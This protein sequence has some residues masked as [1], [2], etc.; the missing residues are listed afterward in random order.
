MCEKEEGGR[1]RTNQQHKSERAG[2]RQSKEHPACT[3]R[4]ILTATAGGGECLRITSRGSSCLHGF[5]QCSDI[6]VTQH[7]LD[8]AAIHAVGTLHT[9]TQV[10]SR[11]RKADPQRTTHRST[12]WISTFFADGDA[13]SIARISV[14]IASFNES[15]QDMSS[16]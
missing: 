15:S 1:G 9:H 16:L 4:A 8:H 11:E 5:N 10:T 3:R 7:T 6:I 2:A 14:L 12:T 13:V